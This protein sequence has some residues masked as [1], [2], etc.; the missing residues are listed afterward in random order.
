M[1]IF[2]RAD[3]EE[4]EEVLA[5]NQ[6]KIQVPA[7]RHRKS[8]FVGADGRPMIPD[9]PTNIECGR[10]EISGESQ[11]D[12]ESV[13]FQP[14]FYGPYLQRNISDLPRFTAFY[15]NTIDVCHWLLEKNFASL[16]DSFYRAQVVGPNLLQL[17]AED[18]RSLGISSIRTQQAVLALRDTLIADTPDHGWNFDAACSIWQKYRCYHVLCVAAETTMHALRERVN[19]LDRILVLSLVASL[20]FNAAAV[21]VSTCDSEINYFALPTF[22]TL[23]ISIGA[24]THKMHGGI[25]DRIEFCEALLERRKNIFTSIVDAASLRQPSIHEFNVSLHEGFREMDRLASCARIGDFYESAVEKKIHDD[26]F[27]GGNFRSTF[28]DTLPHKFGQRI[29]VLNHASNGTLFQAFPDNPISVR[30]REKHDG[31]DT[32]A[33]GNKVVQN[34]ELWSS[35]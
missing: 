31:K 8:V 1:R 33:S 35:Y 25:N 26:E 34:C 9:S 29:I 7:R 32:K 24:H 3:E 17:T 30:R 16:V 6:D 15:W 27:L 13:E 2:Q 22:A 20:I 23:V 18:L 28:V 10:G 21:W 19:L 4:R 12:N 11:T 5:E 14:P